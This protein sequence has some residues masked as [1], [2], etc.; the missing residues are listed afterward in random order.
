MAKV[1]KCK[2]CDSEYHSCEEEA[3][4][5]EEKGDCKVYYKVCKKKHCV[6]VR[7]I[8]HHDHHNEYECKGCTMQFNECKRDAWDSEDVQDCKHVMSEC[9]QQHCRPV[10]HNL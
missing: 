8:V 10:S 6:H 7:P 2:E 4:G 1:N 5:E 3:E 9:R